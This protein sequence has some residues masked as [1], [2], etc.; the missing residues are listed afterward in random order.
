MKNKHIFTYISALGCAILLYACKK[1][2]FQLYESGN[3]I[4][5]VKHVNDSTLSTFLALPND[6][7]QLHPVAVELVGF[8]ED[9]DRTFKMSVVDN[10][11]TAQQTNYSIPES[12]VLR[13][14]RTVDTAWI[15]LR[16]T[17]DIAVATV[18]LVLGLE[19]GDELMVGQT[20]YSVG[21]IIISNVISQ[22]QWWTTT[23]TST[24]LGAY[25]DKKYRLFIEVTGVSDVN[26]TDLNELRYYA[27]M[28][29]NYLLKEKDEGRTVYE[30][31]GNEMT[32]TLLGG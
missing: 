20:D 7:E 31:N 27:I 1:E 12:F 16:K 9:R 26:S 18:R 11:T 28:F 29:K 25:S 14:N 3:Y 13:A 4:Q 17:P 19:G 23:V 6:D 10:L 30:E 15:T 32:V 22:P 8:P 2:G 5:F 24:Y 21:I